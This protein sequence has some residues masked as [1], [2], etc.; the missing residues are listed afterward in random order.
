MIDT[1]NVT[2]TQCI[3]VLEARRQL[4]GAE[5]QDY[6]RPVPACGPAMKTSTRCS[7]SAPG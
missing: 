7:L 6:S 3:E 4:L 5:L 2:L 1:H